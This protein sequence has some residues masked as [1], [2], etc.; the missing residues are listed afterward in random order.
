MNKQARTF[1]IDTVNQGSVD[2]SCMS[3]GRLDR[4]L[5][6]WERKGRSP[7]SGVAWYTD[8]AQ[9][10]R[11][12]RG[13]IHRSRSEAWNDTEIPLRG[14]VSGV[15]WYRDPAQRPRIRRGMIQRSRSEATYQAWNDTEIPPRGHVN[16][17]VRMFCLVKA[18]SKGQNLL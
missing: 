12:R 8:P 6:G 5:F 1:Y 15:A 4:M 9:R 2:T 16:P 7:V 18:L 14:Q 13:M 17:L 11:V 10:P 3:Q